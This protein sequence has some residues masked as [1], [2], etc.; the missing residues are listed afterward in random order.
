MR[1]MFI[2]LECDERSLG[3]IIADMSEKKGIT[4]KGT[5]VVVDD[6]PPHMNARHKAGAGASSMEVAQKLGK[7][8]PFNKAM[9]VASFEAAGLSIKSVPSFLT[10]LKNKKLIKKAGNSGRGFLYTFTNKE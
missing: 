8:G 6:V 5:G 1:K 4:I 7:R 9:L 2:T 3:T 10:S